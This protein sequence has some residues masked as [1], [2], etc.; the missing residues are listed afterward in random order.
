MLGGLAQAENRFADATAHLERAADATHKLGF[1]AA[2]AHH[3]ANL[4][5][6]QEQRGDRQAAIATLQRA[7]ETAHATGD[8]RTGALAGARLGRVLRSAGQ[9]Q[10]ARDIARLAQRWYSTAGGGDGAA[11]AEYVLAALDADE[12][13][14]NAA[15]H[16]GYVLAT[17]RHARDVEVEVLALDALARVNAEQGRTTDAREM[18]DTADRVMSAA[19]HL[20]TDLDR[21]DRDRARSILEDITP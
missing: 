4:G 2:E 16:L 20:V 18:L 9:R 1:V 15:E 19:R 11:L 5:R 14:P 3:L 8:L 13:A 10:P 12:R 17:A 7:I 21:I 6:A